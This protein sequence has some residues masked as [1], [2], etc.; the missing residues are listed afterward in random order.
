VDEKKRNLLS[1]LVEVNLKNQTPIGFLCCS[2]LGKSSCIV[3]WWS[4]KLIESAIHQ[5][6]CLDEKY[7][8]I[9]MM[10]EE[11]GLREPKPEF[12]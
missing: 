11:T 1:D 2:P 4:D 6:K 5:T 10:P 12:G 7:I 8:S 3:K 9:R